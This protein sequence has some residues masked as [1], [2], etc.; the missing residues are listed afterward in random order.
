MLG[1]A[2]SARADGPVVV[3]PSFTTAVVYDDNLFSAPSRS[4]AR[5]AASMGRFTPALSATYQVRPSLAFTGAFLSDAEVFPEFPDQNRFFARR[6]ASVGMRS[7][8]GRDTHLTMAMQYASTRTPR[9]L[10]EETD[11]EFARGHA[12]G[13]SANVGLNRRFGPHHTF[14]L[15]YQ[16]H[17]LDF[18]ERLPRDAHSMS[19]G[20]TFDV[21]RA[22][23]LSLQ[24][25]P[26]YGEGITRA[27]ARV[28]LTHH[29]RQGSLT[30]SY[31]WGRHLVPSEVHEV[32]T[33][34]LNAVT[35]RQIGRRLQVSLSPSYT[36]NY[37]EERNSTSYTLQFGAS[38]P[39]KPWLFAHGSYRFR[40]QRGTL[41]S[42]GI[43]SADG[44]EIMSNIAW[45][46]FSVSRSYRLR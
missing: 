30:L 5:Q 6:R 15:G 41:L 18:G 3:T 2:E 25:G 45:V 37:R 34:R 42:P 32:N 24:G 8:L 40:H 39:I 44:D 21:A 9:D 29:L 7:R 38:Y 31:G 19:L 13:Y 36:R 26:R 20:W 23:S 33:L 28:A 11:L 14:G 22:T 16:Y 35:S 46:G 10:V 12:E 4:T 27:H 17:R 1:A 43:A